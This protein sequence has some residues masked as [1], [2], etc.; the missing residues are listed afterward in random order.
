MIRLVITL[1]I[2]AL[3][4]NATWRIG[5]AYASFY[6]FKDAVQEASQLSPDKSEAELRQRVLN[7]AS[8]LGLPDKDD[9]FS[10]R[11]ENHHT[12]IDGSYT[13]GLEVLPGYWYPWSFTWST[14]TFA[15]PGATAKPPDR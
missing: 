11:R 8:Q 15:I 6:K 14:D 9:S 3:I 1:A 7:L 5:S 10:V 12:Y 2:V 13:Q 4:A